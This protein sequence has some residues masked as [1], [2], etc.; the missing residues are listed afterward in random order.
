MKTPDWN[1]LV[2]GDGVLR[3]PAHQGDRLVFWLPESRDQEF[4]YWERIGTVPRAEIKLEHGLSMIPATS[5]RARQRLSGS[6]FAKLARKLG[7]TGSKES[8]TLPNGQPVEKCGELKTGFL[9]AW[10]ESEGLPVN[11]ES[12]RAHWPELTRFQPVADRLVLLA[13]VGPAKPAQQTTQGPAGTEELGCPIALAEQLL[14]A[15]RQTGDRLKEAAALVD[16][17]ILTMNEGDP[18]KAVAHLEKA[19]EL[20]RQLGNQAREID[21][22]HNLGFALLGAGQAPVAQ[23]VLQ[24]ALQLARQVGDPYAEKLIIERLGVAHLNMRDGYGALQ[25]FD[26]ALEMTRA[27]GDH[28]QETRVL[29]N[30]A[31]A[32][33]DLNQRDQAIA[34]AQESID[35]LRKL[36]KPEAS[37]YGAQLQRY[38]MDFAGLAANGGGM[39]GSTVVTSGPMG[40]SVHDGY[41]GRSRSRRRSW[42]LTHGRLGHQGDDEIHRLGPE[43]DCARPPATAAGHLP[44]LRAPYRAEVPDLRLLHQRQDPDGP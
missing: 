25:H 21:A 31:I 24:A 42:A 27:A 18:R 35:I 38:R 34:K 44:G 7:G 39:F 41:P 5:V 28:Q 30:Q 10:P 17:G 37:W 20:S 29:W 43:D 15:A 11:E 4:Q 2:L 19:V 13:G 33:A 14:E 23:R 36:G 9:L 8:W 32:Y 40:G 16:L 3:D 26:R 12:V 6:L 22:L 1:S